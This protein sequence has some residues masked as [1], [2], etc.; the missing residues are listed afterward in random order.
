MELIK[1][2][3][4]Q[5]ILKRDILHFY[6][7]LYR[8]KANANT[9]QLLDINGCKIIRYCKDRQQFIAIPLENVPSTISYYSSGEIKDY[10]KEFTTFKDEYKERKDSLNPRYDETL[11][12]QVH[13]EWVNKKRIKEIETYINNQGK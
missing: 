3:K 4:K 10:L 12:I 13:T 7:Y 2:I 1:A 6:Q 9:Y 8:D 11:R 5:R